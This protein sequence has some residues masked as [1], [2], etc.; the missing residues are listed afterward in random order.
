MA[1]IY[2]KKRDRARLADSG[3]ARRPGPYR[4]QKLSN[5]PVRLD[6]NQQLSHWRATKMRSLAAPTGI[7]PVF[8]D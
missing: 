1:S 5:L 2:T 7:E 3:T 6:N 4:E 8:P